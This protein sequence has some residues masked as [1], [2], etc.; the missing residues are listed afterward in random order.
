MQNLWKIILVGS[1][2]LNLVAIWGFFHFIRYG[3]SPLGELKRRLTGTTKQT[4][5]SIPYAEENERI[6]KRL[7]AGETDSTRVVFFG[8]SI[9]ARW[10]LERDF[11]RVSILNRGV[12]GQLVPQMLAR[13][14]RDVVDLRPRAVVIKFCSINIRPQLPLAVLKD[15]MEMMT[16][17]ARANDI[18]PVVSTIIPAGKPEAHIGDFSAADSLRAF[19]T[20]VRQYAEVNS[21][22]LIDFAAA[23]ED[24]DGFLP[25]D[26]STDPVHVNERGYTI[27]A[28]AA[29]PVIYRAAGLSP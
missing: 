17:L 13:F 2:L 5:P 4:G 11:P 27:L 26:C 18:T 9:T 12:G 8:A 22:Y 29:R 21:L 23:I 24:D 7:E 14:K 1:I 28:A 3:G 16:Q 6:K 15:G 19:N 25:R 10:D 20:W